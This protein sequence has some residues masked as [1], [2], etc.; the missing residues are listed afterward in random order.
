MVHKLS[1]A[2]QVQ[3]PPE[4]PAP[5]FA[6]RAIK[7]AIF[8]TPVLPDDDTIYETEKE[9]DTMEGDGIRKPQAR[10][11]SPT[12]PPGILLTPGTATTRRKTV[13]FGNEM[14]EKE[15]KIAAEKTVGGSGIPNDCPGKFPSPFVGK[16]EPSTKFSRNTALT[17]KL[18][19]AREGKRGKDEPE[20][21]RNSSEGRPLLDLAPEEDITSATM[22]RS[23]R[24]KAGI[25]Q[26]S[27]QDLL[28]QMITGDDF[29]SDMTM[30]LNEPHSQSG[31]YWKSEY[32]NFH[33][34]AKTEMRKLLKYK[35]LAKSYAKKKDEE[36][37]DLIEKL[38]E[39]QR[40]V[41]TMED[42]ISKLSA[43][44]GTAGLEE[45]DDDSP[46]LI[47]ELA[48]QTA[49]TIQYKGQVEEFRAILEAHLNP[50]SMSHPTYP[51]QALASLRRVS[52]K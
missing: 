36:N 37:L 23:R 2:S 34:E 39:Q 25:P 1:D 14:V 48:R 4:T 31:K 17:R 30:D 15:D 19:N 45:D 42:K 10:S 52:T 38:K 12:K 21:A 11:V 43:Q 13:S 22:P 51:K 7:S 46:E 47:K 35:D 29:L 3:E 6:A 40:R 28:E 41:L 24:R 49:L 9:P 33:E 32:E 5:V 16:P 26:T 8:G 27:N 18:E 20:T 50:P 44:I